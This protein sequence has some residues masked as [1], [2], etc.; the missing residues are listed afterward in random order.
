MT[1]NY[2]TVLETA[3]NQDAEERNL[4]RLY[5]CQIIS[6]KD[7]QHQFS[8]MKEECN[9]AFANSSGDDKEVI[10]LLII[11]FNMDLNKV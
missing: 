9:N 6:K 7:R 11:G 5:C 4:C 8:V 2:G 3:V 10:I 1:Q